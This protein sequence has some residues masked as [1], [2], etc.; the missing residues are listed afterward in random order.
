MINIKPKKN[1]P[2]IEPLLLFITLLMGA[3]PR[4]IFES[5]YYQVWASEKETGKTAALIFKVPGKTSQYSQLA[6]NNRV[7]L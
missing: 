4:V 3:P 6:N 7:H 5:R 1:P 2:K